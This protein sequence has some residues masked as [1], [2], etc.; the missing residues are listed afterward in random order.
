MALTPEE[1]EQLKTVL[2]G[3]IAEMT[4][5]GIKKQNILAFARRHIVASGADITVQIN[6]DG[7]ITLV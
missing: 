7:T 5:A 6:P 1:R 2:Q 3:Q 4:N